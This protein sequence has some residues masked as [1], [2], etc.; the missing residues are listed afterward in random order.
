M[1]RASRIPVSARINFL[2]SWQMRLEMGAFFFRPERWVYHTF[3]CIR[4]LSQSIPRKSRTV[5]K[6]AF[7]EPIS[8]SDVP[9]DAVVEI[10]IQQSV[11]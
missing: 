3:V 8:N 2:I 9:S 4:L 7:L 6:V 11:P 10:F 1:P 5:A